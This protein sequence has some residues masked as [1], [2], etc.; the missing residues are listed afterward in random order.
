MKT[1]TE[2]GKSAGLE[3][4]TL[5]RYVAYMTQRWRY[6]EEQKCYDGYA[7]EWAIRFGKGYEY[8]ASD[9]E[10]KTVLRFIDEALRLSRNII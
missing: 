2:V 8:G 9:I 10:G 1:Y 3:G 4:N 7:E 5:R 6:T